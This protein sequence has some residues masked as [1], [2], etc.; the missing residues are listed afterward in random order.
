MQYYPVKPSDFE[1]VGVGAWEDHLVVFDLGIE[2]D[3]S[4]VSVD[5]IEPG[6]EYRLIFSEALALRK[7]SNSKLAIR[8]NFEDET[9][10]RDTGAYPAIFSLIADPGS[11]YV[12]HWG[13]ATLIGADSYSERF[14]F[15]ADIFT[16]SGGEGVANGSSA[17]S[18]LVMADLNVSNPDGLL[19]QRVAGFNVETSSSGK[20][21]GRCVL[22]R[23][24]VQ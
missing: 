4:I 13:V 22:Q 5:Y 23:R 18:F 16:Q 8:I 7:G 2:D 19:K 14:G 20:L 24:K 9:G 1:P 21:R 17:E 3:V 11:G 6:Y 10:D 12:D 15:Y